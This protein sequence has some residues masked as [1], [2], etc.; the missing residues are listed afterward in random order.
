MKARAITSNMNFAK[1]NGCE[2]LNIAMAEFYMFSS[3]FLTAFISTRALVI[4]D[5]KNGYFNLIV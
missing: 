5:I 3:K 1:A 4:L 2:S